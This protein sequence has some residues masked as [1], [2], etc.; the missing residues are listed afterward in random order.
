M[1]NIACSLLSDELL[2][3]SFSSTFGMDAY[4]EQLLRNFV[5]DVQSKIAEGSEPIG[6]ESPIFKQVSKYIK[7]ILYYFTNYFNYFK[8]KYQNKFLQTFTFYKANS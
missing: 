5:E 6:T 3:D 4:S 7:D 8:A 2:D 1:D